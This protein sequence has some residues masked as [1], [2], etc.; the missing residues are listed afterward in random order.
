MPHATP[1]PPSVPGRRRLLRLLLAAPAAALAPVA[2]AGFNIWESEYTLSRD[3]LQVL[4]SQRFPVRK[5]YA[6]VFSVALRDPQLALDAP[7]NR[8][9]ITAALSIASPLLQAGTVDGIVAVSSALRYDAPARTVRLHEPK[10]ERLELRGITGADADRLRQIG[11]VVAQELLRDQPLRVFTVEEL[12]FGR[13]TWE[14]G[15]ITVRKDVI[16]VQLR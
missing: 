13:K 4:V 10:A 15:E 14:I 5:R 1:A 8:A 12:T 11:A 6:N 9:A 3:E 7:P 2:R 16:A